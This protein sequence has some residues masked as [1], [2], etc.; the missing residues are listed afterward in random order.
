MTPY[1]M[2]MFLYTV[3]GYTIVGQTNFNLTGS[4]LLK[5]YGTNGSLNQGTQA[6]QYAFKCPTGTYTVTTADIGRILVLKSP[7]NPMINS[8]LFR[9]TG[10]DTTNNY[11]FIN[12]RAGATPPAE[13]NMTWGL[14]ENELVFLTTVNWPNG[15]GGVGNGI[16]GTYQGQTSSPQSRIVMQCPSSLAW[17]VRICYENYYDYGGGGGGST[18]PGGAIYSSGITQAVGFGGNSVGDFQPGG[19][20]THTALFF[21]V[22]AGTWTSCT[23]GIWLSGATQ[24]RFYIWGDDQTGT[25]FMAGRSVVGGGTDSFVHFGI[26]EDEEQPLPPLTVQ[27]LFTIGANQSGNSGNN[28]IYWNCGPAF[29]R[30]GMGFGLSNQPVSCIYSLYNRMDGGLFYENATLRGADYANDSEYIAA[31]ELLS[32]DLVVGTLDNNY[33]NGGIEQLILEGR[34]IGRAPIVRLGRNNYGNYQTTTDP[35]QSWI[36]LADGMYLPWQG[37]ILP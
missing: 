29:S 6:T 20:H 8:G 9:V 17:Q 36:H 32:A 14:Y 25:V 23:S 15:G 1:F 33:E 12:Y 27:R 21:N 28:G 11:L 10:V 30:G 26:P 37:P 2:A 4:T 7:G 3:L 24:A 13:T 16:A 5:G 35:N 18:M 19:Q 22:H 31:T 34:R